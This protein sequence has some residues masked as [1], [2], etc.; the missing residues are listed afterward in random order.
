MINETLDF[1]QSPAVG[2]ELAKKQDVSLDVPAFATR[3]KASP[4]SSVKR[5]RMG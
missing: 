4:E 5:D 2:E 3:A 1:D